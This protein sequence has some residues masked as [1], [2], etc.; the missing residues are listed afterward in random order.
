MVSRRQ[1]LRLGASLLPATAGCLSELRE[2]NSSAPADVGDGEKQTP[3]DVPEW[4]PA[5]TLPF[6]GWHVLGLDTTDEL[7][8]ATL[9]KDNGS[10][11]VAAVNPDEQSVLWQTESDGEAVGGSHA[12]YQNISRG[13][14][15]LTLSD[16]T[17]YAVAGPAEERQWSAV[18]ALNQTDGE[19]RWSLRRERELAIAGIADGL[20]VATGLEFFPPPGTTPVSHQ[21]PE[22][23][24]STV[25]YGIDAATG[26][27]R[28]TREFVDV[29]DVA[30]GRDGV[31]VAA[32]NRL[33]GLDWD[34][35][36]Q[37][38]YDRGPATRVEAAAG[39]VF[40][41]TGEESH[42]TL[43]GVGQNG[44][45]DWRRDIPVEELLF[46]G[47]RLYVG[48]DAV[49]AVE[50]DGTVAWRDDDYGQWL[51]LDP[52]RNTLYTRS[53]TAADAAT[54]YDVTGEE[55]WT[56]DPPSNNAW[57]E[58]ATQDVLVASAITADHADQPFLTVYA[59]NAEGQATAA[60]GKDTVFDATGLD[61]TVYLADGASNLVALDP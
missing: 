58:A 19:R 53:G 45:S 9:N 61:G 25:V 44:S 57:P 15:G 12:A 2:T 27:V 40:Y 18:H 7:L 42:V 60:I 26:T 55:R 21:T 51:L 36:T 22:S 13:Q 52:D 14:W 50:T 34:G 35:D 33:V 29:Q 37:F 16:D 17:V 10:S 41:L 32:Q 56:F 46:D 43:H 38:T 3:G 8:Y 6:D 47:D 20:V 49:A 4:T 23:P 54:A 1:A 28:W 11:A 5:W 48:G 39:R 59:V 24:L 31:Y 30:V